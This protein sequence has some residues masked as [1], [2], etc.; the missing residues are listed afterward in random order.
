MEHFG[1]RLGVSKYGFKLIR[2]NFAVVNPCN[3][4][5]P[6]ISHPSMKK[7]REKMRE[8]FLR[9]YGIEMWTD[10]TCKTYTEEWCQWCLRTSLEAYDQSMEYFSM[11]SKEEF[12]SSI[13]A[14]LRKNPQFVPVTDLNLYKGKSGY[15]LM[16]L[17]EYCQA[18]IGETNDI[19]RRIR[20]HW[21]KPARFDRTLIRSGTISIDRFRALDTTRIFVQ[22]AFYRDREQAYINQIPSKFMANV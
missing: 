9:D 1:L 17:D 21:E 16:V 6:E 12:K 19:A 15:Y 13:D 8:K 10:E 7:Y 14:F 18:Y 2:E 3:T 4:F 5:Y 22:K 11:L 20:E